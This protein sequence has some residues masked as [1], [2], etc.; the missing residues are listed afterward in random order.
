MKNLQNKK[1]Q[2]FLTFF[3]FLTISLYGAWL[4]NVPDTMTQPDGT[5][6]DVFYSGDEFHN[7]IH[8]AEEYTMIV[9][10]KSGELCWAREI[11][12]ELVSTGYPVH[13]HTPKS[14]GLKPR[15]NIS[16]ENY[17]KRR[18]RW[19]SQMN[20]E[21]TR[22]PTT[23]TIN[24]LV[25]FIRFAG[26]PEFPNSVGSYNGMFNN[27]GA[28]VNSLKQYFLDASYNQLTVNS[29]YFPTPSGNT[30][31]SYQSPRAR[32]YL[33]PHSSS[34]TIG[35]T[36]DEE[37][38][39]RLHEVLGAAII[40]IAPMVPNTLNI[41]ADNDGRVDNVCFVI[42]GSPDAWSDALW[43]HMWA[44]HLVNVSINGKRVW[45][46]NLN[47]ETSMNN[48]GVGVLAHEFGHTLGAPDFYVYDFATNPIGG[49][50]LMSN[51]RNPPQSMSAFTKHRYMNWI[52]IPTVTTSGTQILNPLHT[53]RTNSAVRINSPNS[54]TQYFIA[55]YRRAVTGQTDGNLPGSGLLVYRVN[56]NATNG[57]AIRPYELYVY[58]PGGTTIADGTLNNAFFNSTV[59][60]T[61]INDSTNPSSFLAN[62]NPGGLNIS[63]IGSAIE[64]ITFTVTIPGS[65]PPPT[66]LTGNY[67]GG[68]ITLNWTAA[69]GATGYKVFRNGTVLATIGNFTIYQDTS[70]SFGETYTYHVTALHGSNESAPSNTVTVTPNEQS[71]ITI[72]T[73]TSNLNL[74]IFPWWDFTYSQQIYRSTDIGRSGTIYTISFLS[75]GGG[76]LDASKDWR[77]WMGHTTQSTF[78]GTES[79]NWISI[80]TQTQVYDAALPST[81][82]VAG[83]IDIPLTTPFV[84]NGTQ[85]IVITISEMT[86]GHSDSNQIFFHSTVTTGQSRSIVA[87]RDGTGPYPDEMWN[88]L[89]ASVSR[90]GYANIKINFSPSV[91]DA[92][93]TMLPTKTALLNNYPNPFN[94][95][96]IIHFQVADANE[97]VRIEIFNIRGQ[98]VRTLANN[99]YIAGEHSVVWNGT[100]DYGQSVAGGIYFYRLTT[101]DFSTTRKMILLK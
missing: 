18:E 54:T 53:H 94:P 49:W 48:S 21:G 98:L 101:E 39:I 55:E 31:L 75:N 99:T 46:Y 69:S 68:I 38:D 32:G 25:V 90:A 79:S 81:A 33:R 56:T 43:P 100:D 13:L 89:N 12:G 66:H 10:A 40:H 67:A 28:G 77:I 93:E 41:D 29:H 14:L 30:I 44:L 59:G 92:D 9:D 73:G 70:F 2:I 47:L 57:N 65:F 50:C 78:A 76:T 58:R 37:G 97:N 15:E 61:A 16:A 24:Q 84:Y 71:V 34:N 86:P 80:Y 23:G 62:G 8:D 85:N 27:T 35:Y 82:A 83:W 42:K 3:L 5:K 72:G 20:R 74:P 22:A 7:W 17:L 6:V 88:V 87:Y 63:G 91:S 95:E 52:T 11:N 1:N 96:T 4:T 64:T 19:E 51:D 36:T 60:R 45:T 26:E